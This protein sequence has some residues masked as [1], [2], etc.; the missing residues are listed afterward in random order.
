M[1]GKIFVNV[2]CLIQH[3]VARRAG[4][5][6][7]AFRQAELIIVGPH[8]LI[9]N[10]SEERPKNEA[11]QSQNPT[12]TA[13]KQPKQGSMKARGLSWRALETLKIPIQE[14]IALQGRL[15]RFPH[16]IS[17]DF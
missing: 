13:P 4:G 6:L 17:S 7:R 11:N 5:P 1:S 8:Q 14:E 15:N 16:P 10:Q 12:K 2:D 9:C 3:A